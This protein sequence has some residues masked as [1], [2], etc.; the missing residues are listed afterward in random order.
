MG[1]I[2]NRALPGSL[3]L[4]ATYN[5]AGQILKD[6]NASGTSGTRTNTYSYFASGSPFAGLLQTKIDGRNTTNAYS[7]DDWLRATNMACTGTLAEQNLT[8]TWQYEP[9][10]FVTSIAEQFASTNTGPA[11]SMQRSFDP[12]GQLASENVS[13]GSFAYGS[14][15]SWNAAGRRTGLGIGSAS[16]GFGWQA[17]GNLTFASDPTGSGSYS[18]LKHGAEIDILDKHAQT[19]LH[20]AALAGNLAVGKKLLKS[21]GKHRRPQRG[22]SNHC[23]LPPM[24]IK[25]NLFGCC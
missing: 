24:P 18:L 11:T 22:G 5:N 14:S 19:P 23:I 17:D 12:Y 6:W 2:T 20:V 8:T 16:Y 15:Q 21:R 10:G 25:S 9:R 7:Y 4:R 3:Q 1:D 13:A